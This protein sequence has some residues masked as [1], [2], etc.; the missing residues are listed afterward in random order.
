MYLLLLLPPYFTTGGML[1]LSVWLVYTMLLLADAC[2]YSLVFI[3]YVCAVSYQ[4]DTF[5][6]LLVLCIERRSSTVTITYTIYIRV[7][8]TSYYIITRHCD[9]YSYQREGIVIHN[10]CGTRVCEGGKEV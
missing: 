9:K 7:P 6:L 4:P 8:G 10:N 2:T 3:M 5:N 1:Y